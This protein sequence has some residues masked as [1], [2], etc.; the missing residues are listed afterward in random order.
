MDWEERAEGH[1]IAEDEDMVLVLT[2]ADSDEGLWSLRVR[3][4]G[5]AEMNVP[6]CTSS[7]EIAKTMSENI[8]KYCKNQRA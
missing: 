4:M 5:K 7:L 8:G 2:T 1:H 3:I 6:L